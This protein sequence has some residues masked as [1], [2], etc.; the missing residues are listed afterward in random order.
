MLLDIS[1]VEEFR[2]IE[3]FRIRKTNTKQKATKKEADTHARVCN[4]M[5]HYSHF[6]RFETLSLLTKKNKTRRK[7]KQ[8]K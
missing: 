6:F 7:V 1:F 8:N 2:G 3:H 4:S 5:P